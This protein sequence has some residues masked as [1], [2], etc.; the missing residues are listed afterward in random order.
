[1]IIVDTC[2]SDDDLNAFLSGDDDPAIGLHVRRCARCQQVLDRLSDDDAL[3]PEAIL[4]RQ[5]GW[6]W[7]DPDELLPVFEAIRGR[8]SSRSRDE[9]WPGANE[10]PVSL[11][12]PRSPGSIG[13]LGPFDIEAEV[14]RGGMGVVY[15]ARDRTTGRLVA[16]KVLQVVGDDRRVRRRFMQEV[17]AAARVDH[18]HIVR[19][20]STS[21]PSDRVP[22]FVM[23]YVAG[24]SLAERTA[25][26][27][28]I[29][30]REAAEFVA[31]AATGVQAAHDSGL[32]HS[33]IKPANI[34]IDPATGRAKVGDFG[35]ARLETETPRHSREGLL[36]GT[37][38]YLSP[39]QARGDPTPAPSSDIYSLGVTLYEC[40]TGEPPFHGKPHRVM[41]RRQLA[42]AY[43]RVGDHLS[44]GYGA[45][46]AEAV[47][48]REKAYAIRRALVAEHPGVAVYRRDLRVSQDKL[49]GARVDTGRVDEAVKLYE[50]SLAA[51][52]AEPVDGKDRPQILSDL[53]FTKSRLARCAALQARDADALRL[54]RE[55]LAHARELC[56]ID[57]HNASYLRQ[58]AFALDYL[59]KTCTEAGEWPEAERTL[60]E[61]RENRRA[62]VTVAPTDQ[63][64]RRSLALAHQDLGDLFSYRHDN[65]AA[66]ASYLEAV[67]GMESIARHD[68]KA[69][70]AY[71]DWLIALRSMTDFEAEIGRYDQA[72]IWSERLIAA[73]TAKGAPNLPARD[74]ALADANVRRD[75]FRLV[76][77]CVDHP[78]LA[79]KQ[80][81]R[82]ARTV[83]NHR[84][85]AL[86]RAG[87]AAEAL[88]A[89]RELLS[90]PEAP[91]APVYAARACAIA[92]ASLGP[93]RAADRS[94]YLKTALEGLRRAI[95]GRVIRRG[96][97]PVVPDFAVFRDEP[98]FIALSR[99]DPGP[100]RPASAP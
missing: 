75:A 17:R 61:F 92:A 58:L 23:E 10:R 8:A 32:V 11:D 25:D 85:L 67:A 22:Y 89:A 15:R 82:T 64:A 2:P 16:L 81:R 53:R 84:A 26:L 90:W 19:L 43:D 57:P 29:P 59:G 68:P 87:R 88:E 71:S 91:I 62:A 83:L 45:P 51:L 36:P 44:L 77:P 66:R 98:E 55:V 12:P 100:K 86:A 72:A 99:P 80:P 9:P 39:E 14:G 54:Y 49:A 4:R 97:L 73:L 47:E 24:P 6:D 95:A 18:D 13:S 46:P 48:Y 40:L 70:L 65:D 41:I 96:L 30:P 94:E 28:R 33:D 56:A 31:Q 93:S 37:P 20:Y 27:G 78:E 63:D 42:N 7:G 69:L 60:V 52:K 3:R 38:A 50:E 76:G 21:D 1:M 34:L 35:L 5:A 74:Q 79:R